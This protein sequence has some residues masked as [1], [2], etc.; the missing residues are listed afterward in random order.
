MPATNGNS[1][2]E[3]FNRKIENS[4]QLNDRIGT[5]GFDRFYCTQFNLIFLVTL[6]ELRISHSKCYRCTF[7][8]FITAHFIN[9][10]QIGYYCDT[11]IRYMHH[12]F[13][14]LS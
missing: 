5:G 10:A 4:L 13:T 12:D 9:A 8:L 7:L 14:L 11:T 6:I 1:R 3:F 2:E